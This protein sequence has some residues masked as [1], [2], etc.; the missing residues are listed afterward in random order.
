VGAHRILLGS[1]HFSGPRFSGDRSQLPRWVG[2]LRDLPR[3]GAQYGVRFS[4][5]EMALILGGNAQRLVKL[6]D[7]PGTR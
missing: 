7:A 2:F 1:D 5:E 6:P 4:E 3:V